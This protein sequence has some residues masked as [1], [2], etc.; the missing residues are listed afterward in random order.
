M[1]SVHQKDVIFS[2]IFWGRGRE[3]KWIN[4]PNIYAG[5]IKPLHACDIVWLVNPGT[6]GLGRLLGEGGK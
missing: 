4:C 3:T 5:F 6:A 2:L 1:L